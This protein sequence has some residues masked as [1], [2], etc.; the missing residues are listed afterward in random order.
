MQKKAV[1]YAL[2]KAAAFIQKTSGEMLDQLSTKIRPNRKYKT[3]RRDLGGSG[4]DVQSL[5]N[6]KW[7]PEFH[8]RTWKGNKYNYCGPNTRLD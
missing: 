7:L 6:H 8:M 2:S 1:D 4:L 3:D 5:P